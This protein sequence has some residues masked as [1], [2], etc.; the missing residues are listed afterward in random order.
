MR[1]RNRL[2][3]ETTGAKTGMRHLIAS[4]LLDLVAPLAL[5]LWI[6]GLYLAL[7][8]LLADVHYEAVTA[9]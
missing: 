6:H 7:T 2:N 4:T 8:T 1:D 3:P 5:L 9:T